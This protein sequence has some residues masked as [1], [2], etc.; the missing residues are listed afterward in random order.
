MAAPQMHLLIFNSSCCPIIWILYILF[1]FFPN[2]LEM[3]MFTVFGL[4]NE[5][6]YA[7]VFLSIGG[8]MRQ[9]LDITLLGQGL[10][11]SVMLVVVQLS[12]QH[13]FSPHQQCVRVP[14]SQ[15][16]NANEMEAEGTS[17]FSPHFMS[18]AC[19][20]ASFHDLW[21]L[22]SVFCKFNKVNAFQKCPLIFK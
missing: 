2:W 22:Y 10:I 12:S 17:Y 3:K 18:F 8:V 15:L 16:W 9:I 14:V 11:T 1:A 21:H 6:P 13:D 5:Y 20:W 19:G 7:F 4:M